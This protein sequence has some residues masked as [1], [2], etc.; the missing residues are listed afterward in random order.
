ME[1]AMGV[2]RLPRR[3]M[4]GSIGAVRAAATSEKAARAEA[5][6]AVLLSYCDAVFDGDGVRCIAFLYHCSTATDCIAPAA[7]R[8]TQ[9]YRHFS[10]K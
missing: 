2:G 5:T 3:A 7:K 1:T 8:V 4:T 9:R 10:A 6:M